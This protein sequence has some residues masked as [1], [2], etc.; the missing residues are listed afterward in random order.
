[1]RGIRWAS[2][3]GLLLL[4]AGFVSACGGDGDGVVEEGE[5]TPRGV[6]EAYWKAWDERNVSR[7]YDL[8]SAACTENL[9]KERVTAA[10]RGGLHDIG[11][12]RVKIESIE[13]DEGDATATAKVNAVYE[14]GLLDGQ[15]AAEPSTPLRLRKDGE[16]W[17][18]AECA[19][20]PT[21]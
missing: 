18:I 19:L 21:S 5:N 9:T 1:M 14:G 10:I 3:L 7:I 13:I 12:S 11:D 8:F 4:L 20:L 2:C 17:K 15:V 16:A 6:V